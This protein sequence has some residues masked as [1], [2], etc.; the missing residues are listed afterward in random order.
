MDILRTLLGKLHSPDQTNL[1]G[2]WHGHFLQDNKRFRLECELQ[3]QGDR[4]TG[5]MRDLD[6]TIE[7]SLLEAVAGLP[8]GA[9]EQYAQQIYRLFPGQRRG[10]I[11]VFSELPEYSTLEGTVNGIF[12]RFTKTYRGKSYHGYGMNGQVMKRALDPPPIEYTGRLSAD[13]RVI[14]GQWTI[15]DR[16]APKGFIEGLFELERV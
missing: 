9:D 5:T 1:T 14:A 16:N 12:V 11:T 6:R 3:H 4:L 15:Y 8:P 10:P 13:G 7:R 2:T